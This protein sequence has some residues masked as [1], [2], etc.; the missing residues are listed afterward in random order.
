MFHTITANREFYSSTRHL[1]EVFFVMT[2]LQAMVAYTTIYGLIPKFL[3]KKKNL[4]FGI[5]LTFLLVVAVAG[6]HTAKYYYLELAYPQSYALH[7]EKFG[8]L[9]VPERV[10]DISVTISKAVF[11]LL[12]HAAVVAISVLQ[13]PATFV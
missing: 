8:Y 13:E 9:S 4:V 5:L 11:F 10:A 6:Y 12:A 7:F 1:L 3:S 2:F